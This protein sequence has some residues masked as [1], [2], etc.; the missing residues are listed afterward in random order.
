MSL[1]DRVREDLEGLVVLGAV[2]LGAGLLDRFTGPPS[3][4]HAVIFVALVGGAGWAT[5]QITQRI[6]LAWLAAATAGLWSIPHATPRQQLWIGLVPLALL[7]LPPGTLER[8]RDAA[9]A[10]LAALVAAGVTAWLAPN[11]LAISIAGA[12]AFAL[13]VFR[14]EVPTSETLGALETVALVLPGGVLLVLLGVN[15]GTAWFEAPEAKAALWTG[16]GVLGLTVLVALALLGLSTLL[17][18]EDPSQ[19]SAWLTVSIVLACLVAIVPSKD[20]ALLQAVGAL[21]VGPVVLLASLAAA[22]F[23]T[24]GVP[25]PVAYAIPLAASLAQAGL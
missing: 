8:V 22:R 3:D 23:Q 15:A 1:V 20:L 24:G 2:A 19:R 18:S 17:E 6:D 9:L 21:A 4:K 5:W 11:L 16:I 10:P 13:T 12:G 7:A 25:W 14:P